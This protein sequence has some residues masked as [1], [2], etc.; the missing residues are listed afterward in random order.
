[1][2]SSLL[3]VTNDTSLSLLIR[4]RA[5]LPC[6]SLEYLHIGPLL[7]SFNVTGSLFEE[8]L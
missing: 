1:M 2:S 3:D 6:P 5:I 8:A 4:K 7:T